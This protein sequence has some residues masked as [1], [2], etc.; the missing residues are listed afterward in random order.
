M[1]QQEPRRGLKG[2]WAAYHHAR[3]RWWVR[4]G[5]DLALF[6]L[7]FM[8]VMAWQTRHLPGSGTPAPDFQLRSLS[9]EQVRLSDLRGKP[10]LLVFWAPWC[11]VCKA[12]S[13]NLAA[14]RRMVGDWAHVV[15]VAVAYED[16]ADVRRFVQD[17]DADYP[18]L[19]GGDSGLTR[20]FRVDRFPTLFVL[21]PEGR[22][23][24]ATIGYSPRLTLLWRLWRAS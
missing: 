11:S 5:V 9:G 3:K 6:A 4:W 10:V 17:W 8:A 21:S 15:T 14:L 22:I 23:D 24:Q 13:S 7:L 12:E 20:S 2:A 1:E 19:L 16:E 18:V